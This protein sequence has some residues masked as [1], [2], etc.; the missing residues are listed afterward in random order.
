MANEAQIGE[1]KLKAFEWRLRRRNKAQKTVEEGLYTV[2][3]WLRAG[4]SLDEYL[5]RLKERSVGGYNMCLRAVRLLERCLGFSLAKDFVFT[6]QAE[7]PAK[8]PTMDQMQRFFAGLSPRDQAVFMVLAKSGLR[9]YEPLHPEPENVDLSTRTINIY[10]RADYRVKN[11]GA[12]MCFTF[13]DHEA[14]DFIS[15]YVKASEA[16][17]YVFQI[18]SK[19][20]S[21][22]TLDE[23][24][25]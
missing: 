5:L 7:K 12:E 25:L 24:G 1:E 14:I 23:V 2:R 15:E 17:D 10:D 22:A 4:Q 19:P 21:T 13:L 9:P 11:A 3:Q 16:Q 6:R 20:V 8:P 18:R